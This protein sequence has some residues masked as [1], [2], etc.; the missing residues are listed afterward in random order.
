MTPE[1]QRRLLDTM[2]E[3]SPGVLVCRIEDGA[4]GISGGNALK[5]RPDLLKLISLLQGRAVD[6]VQ[7]VA[8]DR[9]SRSDDMIE[10][11]MVL[12]A[13]RDAGAVIRTADGTVTDPSTQTGELMGSL[14]LLFATWEKAKIK[15]RT[16]AG[17]L[18]SVSA[19]KPGTGK[20]PYA[21]RYDKTT[22]MWVIV[23]DEAETVQLM[24]SLASEGLG[25]ERIEQRLGELGKRTR[26]GIPFN[27]AAVRFILHSTAYAGTWTQE[28]AGHAYATTVPT[29]IDRSLFDS[30]QTAIAGRRH[31]GGAPCSWDALLRGLVFCPCGRPMHVSVKNTCRTAAK[32]HA[33][34]RCASWRERGNSCGNPS[35]R[36]AHADATVWSAVVEKISSPDLLTEALSD[37]DAI[38]DTTTWEAQVAAARKALERVSRRAAALAEA[39]ADG[40]V[41]DADY[42]Q[43]MDGYQREKA[44]LERTVGAAT[45]GITDATRR[46]SIRGA[47]SDRLA[48]L[49]AT[50]TGSNVPFAIRRDALVA[51]VPRELGCG[52]TLWAD[53]RITVRA[54]LWSDPAGSDSPSG[55]GCQLVGSSRSATG[56]RKPNRAV[57]QPDPGKSPGR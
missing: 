20:V 32:H 46:K 34:Y 38:P 54:A 3:R 57:G 36:A 14:S 21:L 55:S 50:L 2:L 1:N 22:A 26:R 13:V 4:A 43:R 10:R 51:L 40:V 42:R 24:F 15:D 18:R 30:V 47:L 45:A 5:D 19:G 8:L 9:L 7:V 53:G 12:Q 25:V 31:S 28:Y 39:R 17:R 11:A 6:E 56:W 27:R 48:T 41:S 33:L 49:R 44:N 29:I 23:P 52:I 35:F 16:L 37:R